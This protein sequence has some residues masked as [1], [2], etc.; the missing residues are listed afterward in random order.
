[1]AAP[2]D[3]NERSLG[4]AQAMPDF[5]TSTSMMVWAASSPKSA[6]FLGLSPAQ[7]ALVPTTAT[8]FVSLGHPSSAQQYSLRVIEVSVLF[9]GPSQGC[10]MS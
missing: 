1:M 2:S 8:K 4:S 6:R 10:V 9:F 3:S 7:A 5:F